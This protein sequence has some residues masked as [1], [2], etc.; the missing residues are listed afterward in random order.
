M[1]SLIRQIAASVLSALMCA[2]LLVAQSAN[3]QQAPIEGGTFSLQASVDE[4]P[5]LSRSEINPA[6][7]GVTPKTAQNPFGGASVVPVDPTIALI[8]SPVSPISVQQAASQPAHT[9]ARTPIQG[10][11]RGA[12]QHSP[13]VKADAFDDLY[14]V[15]WSHWVTQ[16]ADR[17]FYNLKRLETFYGRDF[18]SPR[19]AQIRFT[20][21][22]NG[23][24]GNI[25][26]EQSSGIAAYDQLQIQALCQAMPLTP[27]PAGSQRKSV[28]LVQ[29]WE[30]HPRRPGEQD[31]RP[32]SF[33]QGF[34]QEKVNRWNSSR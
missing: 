29:G 27:F 12:D 34:P 19:A 8:M 15:D 16:L 4:R 23:T 5:R 31:F 18:H 11:V 22:P 7:V 6:A 26:L 14:S 10:V 30:S 28:T 33:G 32:G 9:P 13:T 1:L 17:W 24:I 25:S 3:A 20:C 2:T 21:Y